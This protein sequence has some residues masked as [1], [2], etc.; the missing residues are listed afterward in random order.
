MTTN[1]VSYAWTFA[2]L[3]FACVMVTVCWS[4]T[5]Y[6]AD[7]R[8]FVMIVLAGTVAVIIKTMYN[9]VTYDMTT[10]NYQRTSLSGNI[11]LVQNISAV[12]P[13]YQQR[14]SD[15]TTNHTLCTNTFKD[16]TFGPQAGETTTDLGTVTKQIDAQCQ[17]MSVNANQWPWLAMKKYC[18]YLGR[19]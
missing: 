15:E 12:C 16:I 11:P 19:N 17:A 1:V 7:Y 8:M 5:L 13:D 4:A 3:V 2:F 10:S 18:E 9:V 14:S 6:T